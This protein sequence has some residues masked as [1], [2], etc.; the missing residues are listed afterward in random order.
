MNLPAQPAFN[1]NHI[2]TIDDGA[3]ARVADACEPG[4]TRRFGLAAI[5]VTRHAAP[6][7]GGTDRRRRTV[8]EVRHAANALGV[9]APSREV[10]AHTGRHIAYADF[11]RGDEPMTLGRATLRGARRGNR[12]DVLAAPRAWKNDFR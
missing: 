8:R 10:A 9:A 4:P 12:S 7:R 3:L 5:L 2:R 1:D 6:S 11:G